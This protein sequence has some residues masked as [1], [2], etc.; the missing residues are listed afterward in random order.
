MVAYS[1]QTNKIM[2][3]VGTM[4]GQR[5]MMF[6]HADMPINKLTPQQTLSESVDL[7]N[8]YMKQHGRDLDVWEPG[9]QDEIARLV[10]VNWIYQNLPHDPI[11]K[12]ILVHQDN[13]KYVV[14]C[15]DTRLMALNL[16]P[17]PPTVSV[18]LTTLRELADSFSDW[19]SITND[20][21]LIEHVKMDP[22]SVSIYYTP[23][24]HDKQYAVSWLEIG[25]TSTST[26]LH[27][28][29]KRLGMMQ[30]YLDQQANDF[31]FSTD[32]ARQSIEWRT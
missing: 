20:A 3:Q 6:Y 8:V 2:D 7:V 13:N 26:H 31:V 9:L 23:T 27:D 29:N 16:C 14:D 12:P 1:G 4:L 5:Y 25:D 21:E 11:R 22:G 18:I 32:W 24:E 28:M 10:N 17:T 30:G 19:D 15:G